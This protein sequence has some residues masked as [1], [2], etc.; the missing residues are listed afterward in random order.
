MDRLSNLL[1]KHE[2]V[3]LKPYV[4]CCGRSWQLCVCEKKGCLTIGIGRNLDSQGISYEEAVMMMENDKARVTYEATEAFDWYLQ[5]SEARQDVVR[6]MIFNMG[7]GRF[8]GFR[9]M[10]VALEREDFAAAANEMLVSQWSAQVGKRAVTLADM[11]R[12]GQYPQ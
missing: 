9:R 3:K 8:K 1:V 12:S 6:S 10:I 4:D 5:L 7:I 2:G 11:M